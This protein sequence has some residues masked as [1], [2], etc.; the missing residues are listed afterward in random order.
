MEGVRR[1][2]VVG[3]LVLLS[4]LVNW[5]IGIFVLAVLIHHYSSFYTAGFSVL[6]SV[7]VS[8]LFSA[9]VSVLVSDRFQTRFR[10]VRC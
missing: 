1:V 8:V 7:L 6:V 9:T 3:V 10:I 5:I 4:Q 2:F